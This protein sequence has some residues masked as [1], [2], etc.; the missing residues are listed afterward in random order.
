MRLINT[1]RKKIWLCVTVALVGFVVATGFT[2]Y[3]NQ[4]VITHLAHIRDLDFHLAMRSNELLNL[5]V[6]QKNFY[7]DS[8]LFGSPESASK[9]NSLCE[10]IAG[11]IESITQMK[12]STH[13]L[14]ADRV[15]G[16]ISLEKKYCEYVKRAT[17]VYPLLAQGKDPG[18]HVEEL[19]LL[20][21]DQ[22][23][24]QNDLEYFSDFYSRHFSNNVTTLMD[25]TSRNSQLLFVF[26][27]VL[28][29]TM[30]L[31]VNWA[32]KLTLI[33]PLAHI[34]DAVRAFG[35]GQRSFPVLE[36]M[37]AE[38]DIG[39]LGA[40]IITMT[41]DLVSTTVSKAY[42]DSILHNMNDS[43]IVTS[44]D[45]HIRSVNRA[46]L[47][48]LGYKHDELI[49]RHINTFLREFLCGG[50]DPDV[51]DNDEKLISHLC[52]NAEKIFLTRDG[53]EIPV[54]LS[55]SC[56]KDDESDSHGLV[57]VAKDITE[58]KK[59]E[60]KL[61][62]M[63][64]YDFLT[65]LPNRMT[66]HDR[67]EQTLKQAHREGHQAG[68]MFLDLDRF[69]EINDTLGHDSGDTLLK[70]VARWLRDCV[71]QS[72]TVARLG[73]DEFA[74]ILDNLHDLQDA[75]NTAERILAAFSKPVLLRGKEI[76]SSP[77]IGIA[78][79]PL[80]AQSIENLLKNADIAMYQAKQNGG[81]GYSFFS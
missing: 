81:N 65:G 36:A 11:K 55:T 52:S 1:I 27:L 70:N 9:G 37:D 44:L 47:D 78:L 64:L 19:K 33:N 6:T 54:L 2:L 48:L 45:F 50:L 10:E 16:L 59:A 43:L 42:V 14:P 66:F 57:F 5:F 8:F 40:A 4:Q 75:V 3:G 25:M 30:L 22:R 63:A 72:D 79:Y 68:L 80:D 53:Q 7:K 31:V 56:L 15:D 28:L 24:I 12:R 34:K 35:R 49:G 20:A 76:Y 17:S 60:E 73:G 32:A 29:V 61:Q 69:K 77:S 18:D 23:E 58:R 13:G 46:A 71:R 26:F 67:L 41:K 62:Q 39:E 74:V 21:D 38:D 51:C